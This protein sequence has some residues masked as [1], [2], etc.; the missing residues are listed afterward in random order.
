MWFFGK[1]FAIVKRMLFCCEFFIERNLH[2][3][4]ERLEENVLQL[5]T[6]LLVYTK[7][8]DQEKEKGLHKHGFFTEFPFSAH[9]AIIL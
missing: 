2:E 9:Q 6:R 1:I 4:D 3:S 8:P 7:I 5:L